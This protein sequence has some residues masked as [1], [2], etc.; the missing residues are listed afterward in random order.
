MKVER[1][2]RLETAGAAAWGDL[3]ARSRLRAPFSGWTWQ[4]AWVRAFAADRRL[5]VWRVAEDDGA[6]VALL[7]LVAVDATTS[8]LVGGADVSDYL[9][10]LCVS[11]REEE[12]WAA[13]LAARGGA[14]PAWELHAVPEASP[15]LGAL[16]R[17]A[18]AAGLVVE[19]AVEERCPVLALPPSWDRYLAGLSG[20]HR[21]EL[22]R[23]MRRLEREAPDARVTVATTPEEIAR[24]FD[25]FLAL[26]RRSRAGK[27]R[28]M[29]ERM[30][31][32]FRGVIGALAA[33]AGAR[34]WFLDA[35]AGPLAAFVTLEWD[36]TVGLYNSG[37]DPE[38]AALSPGLVLLAHV[39][40]DAIERGKLRFD[41]LRGE[42]RY[43]YDF[44]PTPEAVH[45]VTIRSAS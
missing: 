8:L 26:H 21:H 40:R 35:D 32:F 7:P 19:V 9:D 22:T 36:G 2:D 18:A 33:A 28:F 14:G 27:A 3:H 17:L 10:L 16:P 37:F 23:K 34:L 39:V 42:E 4:T 30:E 20:K 6:L 24:R 15:T 13:L 12:A 38:R 41:F 11:G 45:A 5:E 44:G 25:D 1:H 29:D 31:G 43:K